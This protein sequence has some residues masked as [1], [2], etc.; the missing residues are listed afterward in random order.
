[1]RIFESLHYELSGHPNISMAL[2]VVAF[3]YL[4]AVLLLLTFI[5]TRDPGKVEDLGE[6]LHSHLDKRGW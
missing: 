6:L 4:G 1:M 5:F 3:G 2:G